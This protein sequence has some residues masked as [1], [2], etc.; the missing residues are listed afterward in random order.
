MPDKKHRRSILASVYHACRCIAESVSRQEAYIK[1][2]DSPLPPFKPKGTAA[3]DRFGDY[4]KYKRL[5]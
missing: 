1:A 4:G 2:V 3:L 5:I